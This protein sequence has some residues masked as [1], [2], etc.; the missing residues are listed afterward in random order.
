M[1]RELSLA[2][3]LLHQVQCLPPEEKNS[4]LVDNAPTSF[5]LEQ[6]AEMLVHQL[7]RARQD[8]M[9]VEHGLD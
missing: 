6:R 8:A 2:Y 5:T 7:E 9:Y 3:D 4:N 1:N